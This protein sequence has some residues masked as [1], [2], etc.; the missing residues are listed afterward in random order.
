MDIPIQ[1]I[2]YLLSYAWNKLDEKDRINISSDDRTELLELLARVL[3]NGTRILLKRGIDRSYKD[4][5]DEISGVKGKLEL[6]STLKSNLQL[7]QRTICNYDN[8]SSNIISNQI[9]ITTLYRLTRTINLDTKIKGEIKNILWMFNEVEAIDLQSST[10]KQVT[11]NRNN[12]FY[13]FLLNVCEL[14]YTSSL[15]LEKNGTWQ[16]MD[17]MRDERKMNQLFEAFIRN[18]YK[19]E[20]AVYPIVKKEQINWQFR[21][22]DSESIK[23]LPI[24]ETDIT[25]E[26]DNSKIIIDAKFYSETMNTRYDKEKI[27][28][29]NLYQLFS[30]LLNQRTEIPKTHKV[31]GMLLYPTIDKEYNLKY[32]Y[33]GHDIY[34]KTLNLN[35][36]WRLI[37]KRLQNILEEI[38]IQ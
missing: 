1:N 26:N 37:E 36:N 12:R 16:F 27:K 38:C 30:Y 14:I 9:L 19:K 6:S 15:P 2:Y 20:Q 28:S 22:S 17:F 24:M 3:I 10:F 21:F 13:G 4:R 31:V 5:T 35:Q 34:I 23:Y 29:P 18:F 11:L 25:L 8:F 33:E 7:K 32:S